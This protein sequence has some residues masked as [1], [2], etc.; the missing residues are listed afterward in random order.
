[1]SIGSK[2]KEIRQ[3]TDWGDVIASAGALVALV[4]V[5]IAIIALIFNLNMDF[6][7]VQADTLA[8]FI[9]ETKKPQCVKDELGKILSEHGKIFSYQLGIAEE[10]CQILALLAE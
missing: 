9:A 5:V 7:K 10:N 6:K 8:V 1:M 4:A 2:W 3:R